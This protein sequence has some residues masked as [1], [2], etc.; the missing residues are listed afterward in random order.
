MLNPASALPLYYQLKKQLLR[1]IQEGRWQPKEAIPSE[2]ELI[3]AYGVSR[4]TVRQALADLVTEGVLY[5][6]QGRGTFVAPAKPIIN[7]LSSLI[8]HVEE[9]QD[10]GLQPLVCVGRIA[11]EVPPEA[12]AKA[13]RLKEDE[14]AQVIHRL[15]TVNGA[16]YFKIEAWFPLELGARLVAQPLQTKPIYQALESLGVVPAYGRQ[17]IHAVSTNARE[18]ELL[19]LSPGHAALE[20]IRTIFT[21]EDRPIEWSRAI[22]HP[23]RYEYVV[24][25]RRTVHARTEE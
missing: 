13:L 25:L 20:V 2:R 4:T 5:R 14:L 10:R 8:G 18:A 21:A 12:G 9:L 6:Q 7:S 17:Q 24:D 3:D 19:D 11:V 16:S 23:E 22:Y 1:E 15:V